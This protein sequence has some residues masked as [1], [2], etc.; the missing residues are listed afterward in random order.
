MGP[1]AAGRAR[2]PIPPPRAILYFCSAPPARPYHED[3]KLVE[4][5]HQL[6]VLRTYLDEAAAGHGRA[7]FVTGEAGVGKSALV[8]AFADSVADQVHVAVAF[9]DGSATPSPLAP[10]RDLLPALPTGL[11]PEH[12]S[13]DD[14]FANVVAALRE[15]PDSAPYV[16]VIED[17]HWADQATL[18]LVLH[19]ARRV[20]GCR[21]LV[22][23]TYRPEETDGAHGLQQ[24]VGASASASGARRLDVPAL[25][26]R[27]V[28]NLVKEATRGVRHDGIDPTRLYEITHGN[29]FYVSEVLASGLSSVPDRCRDAIVARVARL[30]PSA[31]QA[32]EIVALAGARADVDLLAELL[33]DGLAA[34][35]EALGRGLLVE[36]DGAITFRHE[37]ARL[38]VENE[39]PIGRRTHQHRRLHALLLARGADSAKLAHHADLA[40]LAEAALEH[41]RSAGRRASELGAHREA[42][43]QYERALRHATRLGVDVVSP[44]EVA[45]LQW[46]LG[47]ELYVT[48]RTADAAIAVEAARQ[49]WERHSETTRVG[50]AWRCL[51]RLLWF[52]GDSRAAH[53]AAERALDILEGSPTAELAY[54]Y[55]NMTQLRMLASDGAATRAWGART[56]ALLDV[57][58]PGRT[59][60]ELRSHALN[61]LGTMEA[62]DGQVAHG[63]SMLEE[64][65]RL[66]REAELHEHAA[67]AYVNLASSATAQRRHADA[68]RHVTE[69]LEYCTERDL[70]SWTGY[71]LLIDAD[72]RLDLGQF[73]LAERQASA[74]L[75]HPSLPSNVAL[76]PL[77][78]LA[79]LRA[80]RAEGDAGDLV[81][82]AMSLAHGIDSV[83]AIAPVGGLR[84]ELAWLARRDAEIPAVASEYLEVANRADCRWNRGIVARWVSPADLPAGFREVA[85]PF[86]AELA[87]EWQAAASMWEQ[88]GCP[89]DHALALAR[90]CEPEALVAAARIFDGLKAHAAAARCRADLRAQGRAASRAPGR[91]ARIHPNGFTPRESEVA[92]LVAEGMSDAAIA[93]RLV[94]SRRTVEH[95]VAAILAK[96]GVGSRRDLPRA[97]G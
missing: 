86:A 19:V 30:S 58:G 90:S 60:T 33:D 70:D 84:C 28:T 1:Y 91:H 8:S 65:L 80:R 7:V 20:H 79:H 43:R 61:N 49:I 45:D 54:A 41:A 55:S 38:V 59:Q 17:A 42:A 72:L 87:G 89:F 95:H 63:V 93:E 13:R 71:L 73:D 78:V 57:L 40:G 56:L 46:G 35:D 68:I 31:R 11:W 27:A 74:V 22:V 48:G 88:L 12:A 64:S 24:I 53:A 34:L 2:A 66:A 51:S 6:D 15:P 85:P 4:R 76:G 77:V 5:D 26:P 23:I 9:C 69:G 62:V 29:A 3:V 32:L 50:D 39:I 52:E 82:R 92:A 36:S 67:R 21:A 10:L 75:D 47:Y 14:I 96:L 81:D 25:T 16:V 83:E 37:L 18:D 97:A 44:A 94:L